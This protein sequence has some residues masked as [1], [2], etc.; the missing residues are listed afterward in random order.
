MT[1]VAGR[2]SYDVRGLCR[3]FRF[4]ARSGSGRQV[5]GSRP[6]ARHE[7]FVESLVLPIGHR[8]RPS[9]DEQGDDRDPDCLEVQVRERIPEGTAQPKLTA[10]KARISMPPA[11]NADRN[12]H[13]GDATAVW[14]L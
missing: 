13:I 14:D 7:P 1:T 6:L 8:Q 4:R 10:T 12:E 9:D 5:R 3:S 11:P 2:D